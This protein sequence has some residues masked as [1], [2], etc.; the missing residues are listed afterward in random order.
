MCPLPRLASNYMFFVFWDFNQLYFEEPYG[1]IPPRVS[2]LCSRIGFAPMTLI[3]ISKT[4]WTARV[5]SRTLTILV[6]LLWTHSNL[7][8]LKYAIWSN[9]NILGVHWKKWKYSRCSLKNAEYSRCLLKNAEMVA[10]FFF[11]FLC[12]EC[13]KAREA[14]WVSANLLSHPILYYRCMA[15]VVIFWE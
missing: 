11:S 5:F 8:F 1:I 15:F 3:L 10:N 6:V 9:H 13:E 12:S 7:S 14:P 2:S 4:W